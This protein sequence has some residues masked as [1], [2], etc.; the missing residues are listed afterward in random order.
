VLVTEADAQMSTHEDED[1]DTDGEV[2]EESVQRTKGKCT[3]ARGCKI[4]SFQLFPFL[5]HY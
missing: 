4:V 3:I 5:Y 1:K 2:E